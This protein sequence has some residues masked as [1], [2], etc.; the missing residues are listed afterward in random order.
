MS[1][2]LRFFLPISY[3]HATRL[4][5]WPLVVYNAL[6]E[7][8]PAISLSIYFNPLGFSVIPVV[9]LSYGAFICIYEIGY[10]TNDFFS[11]RFETDPRGRRSLI[12]DNVAAV[13]GII[14]SRIAFFLVFSYVA[15]ALSSLHWWVFHTLLIVTFI[16]HNSLPSNLRVPTFFTLST[17]RFFGP[18]ILSL[19]APAIL[20]LLPAILLNNSLYRTTVYIRNKHEKKS[21]RPTVRFKFAFYAGC[22]P[23]SIMLAF[24]QDSVLPTVVC[25]Y[26]VL[27]WTLYWVGSRVSRSTEKT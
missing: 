9:L 22:L 27:I 18:L 10:I 6:V 20:L 19:P 21:D 1:T 12:R 16:L 14:I 13:V 26:F 15:G 25:L 5:R 7:W 2:F 8:V 17:F 4:N 23:F 11:E 24:L 3:F